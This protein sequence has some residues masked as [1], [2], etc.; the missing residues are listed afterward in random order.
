MIEQC[1][2]SDPVAKSDFENELVELIP[3]MRAFARSLCC[4]SKEIADDPVQDTLVK[5]WKSQSFFTAETN[6]KA[7]L[8][9]ILH[10][11]FYSFRRRA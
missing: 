10:N 6:L 9:T 11:E 1:T 7:W 5:A 8:F 2:T 4:R 3:F